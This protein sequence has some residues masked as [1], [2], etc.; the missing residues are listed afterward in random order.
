MNIHSIKCHANLHDW[1]Y[2]VN[3]YEDIV[4]VEKSCM[5]CDAEAVDSSYPIEE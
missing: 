4:V 3:K 1:R 5:W 2:T